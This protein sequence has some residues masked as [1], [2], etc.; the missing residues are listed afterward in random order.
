MISVI[1]KTNYSYSRSWFIISSSLSYFFALV[2]RK[3]LSRGLHNKRLETA[4]TEKVLA[5]GSGED[6]NSKVE[7]IRENEAY[8]AG[9][10][11]KYDY[12]DKENETTE[13]RLEQIEKLIQ[14]ED[15]GRI[16]IFEEGLPKDFI[17]KSIS[18]FKSELV[19]IG[20]FPNFSYLPKKQIEF[21]RFG[22]L[23]YVEL[24]TKNLQFI[25]RW[26]KSLFDRVFSLLVLI[27]LSPICLFI[28]V[29]VKISSP[30]PILYRQERLTYGGKPFEL[31]KF[32]SMPVTVEERSGPVWAKPDDNRATKFGA[33]LRGT[34]L[35][36][37]PQFFNVLKGE[38]SVVG[39][40][41]E[42][43]HFVEQFQY[44]VPEYMQKHKVKAGITG[45]SQINGFRG[46][47]SIEKRVEFD[48]FYINNWSFWLDIKIIIL[49]LFKGF[50]A[51]E[52]Y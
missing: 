5:L 39:P 40:R 25:D 9:E 42:R 24:T 33:F 16:W 28:A 1:T 51:D 23:V 47:T 31:L 22:D 37:L 6:L 49:T 10:I 13:Q 43:P 44:T 8:V 35:D 4:A 41:P 45:W 27:I 30:G 7:F 29:G 11:H 38:M 19:N 32:R 36:E 12:E 21:E 46:N 20:Y 34:S 14:R 2:W 3:L 26:L 18:T 17:A 48:L 15:I 52:A 50:V